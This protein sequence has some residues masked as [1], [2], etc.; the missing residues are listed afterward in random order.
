MACTHGVGLCHKERKN[1]MA[2]PPKPQGLEPKFCRECEIWGIRACKAVPQKKIFRALS[3]GKFA[4][5]SEGASSVESASKAVPNMKYYSF[6]SLFI[7]VCSLKAIASLQ[8]RRSKEEKSHPHNH[9]STSHHHASQLQP[10]CCFWHCFWHCC[11][12]QRY[13]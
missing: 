2:S 5:E 1:V 4:S 13:Y 8:G 6:A 9:K 3:D 10:W 7:I 11:C 12:H